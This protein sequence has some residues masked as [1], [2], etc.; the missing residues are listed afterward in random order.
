MFTCVYD[1]TA[2]G[3]LALVVTDV[4]IGRGY[5]SFSSSC[6]T[7]LALLAPL[8]APLLTLNSKVAVNTL[9]RGPS[10]GATEGRRETGAERWTSPRRTSVLDTATSPGLT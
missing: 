8:L 6:Y 4:S 9:G 2:P 5:T 3:L 7:L 1:L 10:A